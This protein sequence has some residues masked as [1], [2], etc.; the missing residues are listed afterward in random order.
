M[1]GTGAELLAPAGSWAALNA[2]V[3]AGADAVYFGVG[4]LNMR[5]RAAMNFTEA[6]LTALVA[7]CRE[8]GVRAYLT[9]NLILYDDELERVDALCEAAA[10][11]D[12]DAVICHDFAV[13]EAARRKGLA[14][15]LSTQANVSNLQAVRFYANYADVIVL[16]RELSLSRMRRI[17]RGIEAN[18]ILG[19]AG[20]G[21]R[22]EAF[23]HG[24]LC[25]AVSG[26]CHMSLAGF[27]HS[28][29]RGD[30][31]QPCRRAYA[32]TD[33]ET[34]QSFEIENQYVM[35]PSDLCTLG[36]LPQLLEAGVSVFKIEGR[37][38][39][40]DYVATTVACYREALDAIDQGGF[41]NDAVEAWKTRLASVFNRGFWEGGYYLDQ[42]SGAWSGPP[43]NK[44]TRRKA[45]IGR[46]VNYYRRAGVAEVCIHDGPLEP[47]DSLLVIGPTTG[48]VEFSADSLVH[49]EE[50]GTLTVPVPE[51]V[52]PNDKVFRWK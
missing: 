6:D 12:V 39:S 36:Q 28:A 47:G 46:V 2:A 27:N 17:A 30:C 23:V 22:I 49:H 42:P 48:V 11:A 5:A 14:V 15:H 35:S 25:V 51:K 21:L 4:H 52:R 32:V 13:I 1:N 8:A 18:G 50:T 31:L 33:V 44:A 37:G 10:A 40:A 9:L 45:Q 20:R 19:P 34:G 3:R 24:A 16:A 38:R 41:T 43:E 29:N 26:K 7:R